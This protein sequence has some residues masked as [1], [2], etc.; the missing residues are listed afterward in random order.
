MTEP[1]YMCSLCGEN[2][3]PDPTGFVRNWVIFSHMLPFVS[4]LFA[5]WCVFEKM[6]ILKK[7]IYSVFLLEVGIIYCAVASMPELASHI[8]TMNWN[9][10]YDTIESDGILLFYIFLSAG[11]SAITISLRKAGLP[12]I[13]CPSGCWDAVTLLVDWALIVLSL[14]ISFVYSTFGKDKCIILVSFTHYSH[15]HLSFGYI[16]E[17][18]SALTI[19]LHSL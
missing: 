10:C 19:K 16:I 11:F 1:I 13:R 4:V 17:S 14:G 15:T 7:R 12:L 5:T 18:N 3:T 6:E 2:T 8:Y 9:L